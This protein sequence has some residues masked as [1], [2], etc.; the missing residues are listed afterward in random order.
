M[1]INSITYLALFGFISFTRA[2]EAGEEAAKVEPI[3]F[4]WSADAATASETLE[5]AAVV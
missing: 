1:K 5:E 3:G 2:E 4:F